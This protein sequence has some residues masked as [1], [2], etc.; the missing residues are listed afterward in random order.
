MMGIPDD[1]R[2]E[3]K[4]VTQHSL[5]CIPWDNSDGLRRGAYIVSKALSQA[6]NRAPSWATLTS[7]NFRQDGRT[8]S[9]DARLWPGRGRRPDRR[10]HT[11]SHG[12]ID[13]TN[14]EQIN[15]NAAATAQPT[16][17]NTMLHA[18]PNAVAGR[19]EAMQVWTLFDTEC[20]RAYL[21]RPSR[22]HNSPDYA[23]RIKHNCEARVA[24]RHGDG[25]SC[26]QTLALRIL[27]ICV[28]PGTLRPRLRRPHKP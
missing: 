24:T 19:D 1:F 18:Q 10:A 20:G 26:V 7:T 16:C 28:R 6:M 23:Q 12:P 15:N 25:G 22:H 21:G 14:R 5:E 2:C 27:H 13:G 11:P 17:P 9:V 8:R 3:V 4:H